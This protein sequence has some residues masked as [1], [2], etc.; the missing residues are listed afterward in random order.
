MKPSKQTKRGALERRLMLL[1][2]PLIA[3][4]LVL[5]AKMPE[6]IAAMEK[7]R[8]YDSDFYEF[9]DLFSEVYATI[10]D[11]YVEEVPAKQLFE[12]AINGMFA[13]L[14]AHSSWMPPD[15]SEMLTRDTEGE[16]SGVGLHISLD[17]HKILTVVTPIAGSPAAQAGVLPLDR[18]IE[19]EGKSTEN[20]TMNEAVKKLTGPTGSTVTIKV[21]R[22]GEAKPLSF[23]LKRQTIKVDSVFSKVMEG[24]VGYLRVTKFQEDTADAMRKALKEFNK[25]NVRGVIVDLRFNPG[26][27]LDK[28]VETCDLFLPKGQV[29]VSIKGRN[30][31]NVH[32]YKALEEPVCNQPLIVLINHGSASASEIFAGA[33]KDTKRGVIIGPKGISTYGKG[34]VQTISQV[35]KS[36]DKDKNGDY[37]PSGIRLTTALYYTPAGVSIHKKGIKPDVGVEIPEGH[38]IDVLR[39]GLLGD[40]D[41]SKFDN[42]A[43]RQLKNGKN[44]KNGDKKNSPGDVLFN[45]EM[46]HPEDALGTDEETTTTTHSLEQIL[47]QT[48]VKPDTAETTGT[49]AA[50]DGKPEKPAEFHDL[51]LE[52]AL[53]RMKTTIVQ[54]ESKVRAA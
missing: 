48:V 33:M 13:T 24:G 39:H 30:K 31:T 49:Q 50:K 47:N 4:G 14:D 51:I 52:E 16:Y 5:M 44:G 7:Q 10:K 21:W 53:K 41:M 29:I 32:E 26:G 15:V 27:L 9:A 40:P 37:L 12:G 54:E 22:A 1:C 20:I 34:S 43:N 25:Q 11:R 17:E 36:L 23:T 45:D 6:R 18:I 2:L 8:Q 3:A 35:N 28:A 46:D 19:I 42:G 38:E